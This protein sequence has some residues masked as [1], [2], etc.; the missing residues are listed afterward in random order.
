MS[1]RAMRYKCPNNRLILHKPT[2]RWTCLVPLLVGVLAGGAAML[3]PV[4]TAQADSPLASGPGV[5]API[6][7]GIAPVTSANTKRLPLLGQWLVALAAD[8]ERATL[9]IV[10]PDW[11][12]P[13]AGQLRR[14]DAQGRAAGLSG[15]LYDNRDRGHSVLPTGRFPQINLTQYDEPFVAQHLDYGVAGQ[16]RFGLPVIGNSSTAHRAAPM[17]RSLGRIAL[18][19][20]L[21]AMRAHDLYAANHIY[22][23]P[24]HRDHDLDTGDRLFAQS[25]AFLLSQGSS[26]TDRPFLEAFAMIFAALPPETR[27]FA[28]ARGLLAPLAQ[29]ILRRSM[30]G[31]ASNQDYLSPKAHP[32]AF[33]GKSL[34]PSAMVTLANSVQPDS[35]PPMVR[36][37]VRED[38]RS[39]P[40]V[41]YLASNLGEALF[42]T[43]TAIGRAWRSFAYTRRIVL[44]AGATR[45][46]NGHP[47][48]FHWVVL[49][50]DPARIRFE[51]IS[52]SSDT[53][54]IEID[55]HD[56][57][58]NLPPSIPR[59]TRVEIGVFADNG[60]YL[61]APSFFSVSLPVFQSRVYEHGPSGPYLKSVD[62]QRDATDPYADP[63]LWPTADWKDKLVWT[64]A[65]GALQI[66]RTEADATTMLLTRDATMFLSAEGPVSHQAEMTPEGPL[67]LREMSGDQ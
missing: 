8:P 39:R 5:V 7:D 43:P 63:A 45:D 52:E 25:P 3:G 55:W 9:P 20:Q 53:M 59:P 54:A 11:Q 34:R 32:S 64:G 67:V 65:G 56:P 13:V 16:V 51:P 12:D 4:G 62:Y 44:D 30:A 22:V 66:H 42:T 21:N 19:G 50:G 27:A 28:E 41:D 29:M 24:E 10:D 37:R 1:R 14:L 60:R 38:F 17:D 58:T 47:L 35:V 57:G 36:L 31:V 46:P 26:Y 18:A 15:V 23:Y 33:V 40:G 6:V 49:K 48:R 2:V 61:S